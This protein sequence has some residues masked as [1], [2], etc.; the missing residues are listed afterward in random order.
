MEKTSKGRVKVGIYLCAILMMGVIAVSSN[1]A[2]I[3]AAF[4]EANQT[5]VTTYLISISFILLLSLF[6]F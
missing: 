3:I 6:P 1:I 4:P 2:N 5:T